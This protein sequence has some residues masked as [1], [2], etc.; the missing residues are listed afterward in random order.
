MPEIEIAKTK[1]FSWQKKPS[2]LC[3]KS[4][5]ID[6]T[7]KDRLISE[8]L[9]YGCEIAKKKAQSKVD[10]M[11]NSIPILEKTF[12]GKQKKKKKKIIPTWLNQTGT[13]EN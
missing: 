12:Y 9:P 7:K 3:F 2:N 4:V 10:F 11:E 13:L 6:F 8:Y 1:I 5:K